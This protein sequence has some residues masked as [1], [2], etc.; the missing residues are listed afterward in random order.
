[1]NCTRIDVLIAAL[2]VYRALCKT[3]GIASGKKMY[4]RV[5]TRSRTFKSAFNYETI[6]GR[7]VQMS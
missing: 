3:L 6:R 4:L 1:M 7:N 5:Y 2:R